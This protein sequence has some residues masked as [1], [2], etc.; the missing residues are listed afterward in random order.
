[1]AEKISQYVAD[2]TSNPIKNEDYLD[3]SNEDGGGG[4]D[5]SKKILVS[6]LVTF[7]NSNIVNLY[8]S[9]GTL[10]EDRDVTAATFYTRWTGGNVEVAMADEVSSYYFRALDVSLTEKARLG[11]NQGTLS[12]EIRLRNISGIFFA[13]ND[14]IFNVNTDRLYVDT[15]NVGIG[16]NTP[17]ATS[18]LDIEFV[19]GSISPVSFYEN[20]VGGASGGD[21]YTIP[22]YFNDD[23]GARTVGGTIIARVDNPPTTGNVNMS[24]TLHDTIKIQ[25]TSRVLITPSPLTGAAVAQLE[26]RGSG[27]DVGN[28]GLLVKSVGSTASQIP[29]WVQN[30]L[31]NNLM[32]IDAT[33]KHFH[34]VS[35]IATADFNMRGATNLNAFYFNAGTDN[36]GFGTNTPNASSI[37]EFSSTTKGVRYTPMTVAQAGLIS[38]VEGLVLFVSDT[39]GTFPSI[40]LYCYENGAWN[41]L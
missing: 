30:S 20:R 34:N 35:Q 38:P 18:M 26:V 5:V 9:D 24:M 25:P 37:V 3:L 27:P 40:G 11:Y 15:V 1:M 41:K 21:N 14:G 19:E 2:A 12:G 33:G 23:I 4:Y 7:L 32:Y 16:T 22:F 17:L 28:T 8:T 13:A 39:D 10:P 6:E 36:T 31:N 29:F